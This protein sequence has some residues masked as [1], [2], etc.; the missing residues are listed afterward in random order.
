M[1]SWLGPLIVYAI[2]VGCLLWVYHDFDWHTELPR[3][4][5]IH[6]GWIL[7]AIGTDIL[8]YVAQAWRWNVL[9]SPIAKVPLWRSVQAIYVGLFANEVLPLRSGELIRCYLQSVW[10][11]IPLPAVL[12]SALLERLVDGIWLMLGFVVSA[13]FIDMPEAVEVGGTILA[14][15]VV[16]LATL[17]MFAILSRRFSRHVVTRHRW[18][19]VLRT[20]V[21]DVHLLGRSRSFGWAVLISILFLGL[22]LVPIYAMIRGYGVEDLL[23]GDAAVVL[24]VIRLSTVVPGLPGNL[25]LF[26]AAAFTALHKMLGVES[27]VAKSISAI[28]FFVI[29]VPLLIAGALALAATGLKIREV[30]RQAHEG[31]KR[32]RAPVPEAS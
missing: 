15:I 4:R 9:L 23:I 2:S 25:G 7:L 14:I 26:N 5:H 20:L 17:V 31:K 18:S 29:T 27:Q 21:E 6:W 16:I 10:S 11:A 3:L 30:Y 22:Q 24:I 19:E 12:A 32:K 8:V 13:L 28:M 1:P